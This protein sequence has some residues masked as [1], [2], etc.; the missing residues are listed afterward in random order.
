MRW[1]RQRPRKRN[2]T[3]ALFVLFALACQHVAPA[4]PAA[5]PAPVA[6]VAPPAD[7]AHSEV[8]STA[9]VAQPNEPA[10]AESGSNAISRAVS[11]AD[12]SEDDRLLDAQRKPE[13]MLA[14]FEIAPKMRV[15]ELGAAG[16]YTTELLA[17]VVG[18]KGVVY[19]Q[20]SRFVLER[21]AEQPW[22]ER[23]EKPV[24]A[25]VKRVD[26]PFDAPL[27]ADVRDLDA[28]LVVLFYHDT[29]WLGADRAKMNTA[30]FNA[31]KPGG[32]YGI[33]DHSAEPGAG[34]SHAKTLHRVE[35]SAVKAE[36]LAAGFEFVDSADFLRNPDDKRDWNA[37]PRA[38]GER[39]GK[40]DRF[41]L[42]FKKP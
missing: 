26:A 6:S 20:N 17:R 15:A 21:F 10:A 40:S 11:A 14:F 28:V 23:L 42:K 24:N 33:V 38:A 22:S 32:I 41:V 18:P 39:R 4:A 19:G 13:Q 36:I 34:M 37:A 8:G 5:A 7:A 9:D 31:L 30:V 25:N 16:G 35:E 12:R 2:G 29:V 1:P 3:F 27:P